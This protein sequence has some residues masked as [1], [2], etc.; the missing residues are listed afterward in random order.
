MKSPQP[1]FRLSLFASIL[2]AAA[3]GFAQTGQ[4]QTGQPL[5]ATPEARSAQELYEEANNYL[6][7]KFEEFNKQKL[8]Y[9]PKL[10]EKTK[11]EQRDLAARHAATLGARGELPAKE[12]YYHGML[13][14]LS[15]NSELA[16][17]VMRQFIANNPAGE[18]PQVARAVVVLHAIKKNLVVEAESVTEAY[19]KSQPQ[20]LNELYGM[21]TLLANAFAQAK[22]YERVAQ[23]AR[24]ML[25]AAISATEKKNISGFTRDER[26]F[27]AASTLADALVKAEKPTEAIATIQE[28]LRL[29]LA[30][31]SGNLYRLARYRLAT[32]DP[33]ADLLKVLENSQSTQ[34]SPARLPPEIVA[35]RWIDQPPVKLSELRGRVVLLDFWAPWCGPCR[36][37]FPKLQKWYQ[38]YKDEGLVILGM[39]N[40]W[41]EAEGRRLNQTEEL[42]YLNDFKKKN[43]LPYGFVIA[44]SRVNDI[45]YGAFTLPMSFLIDRRGRVRFIA[46]G[47]NDPETAALDKMIKQLLAEP[48]P[49]PGGEKAGSAN[50]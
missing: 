15:G 13:Y 48:E 31:P 29:S 47:G 45:N 33:S 42:A 23:H 12:L 5:A 39:T 10:E 19:T 38:N 14:H 27:K 36:Y 11:Q 22:D 49:E 41:G 26:L 2:L 46:L 32:L 18:K 20:D 28:L 17:K 7:K 50:R 25:N 16:L 34:S 30:L 44:D 40:Y 43:R 9:D 6:N 3:S 35:A 37:T 8:A 21:E 24:G 4:I 1:H